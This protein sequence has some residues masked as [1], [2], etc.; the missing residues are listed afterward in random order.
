MATPPESF[1]PH[2]LLRA[3]HDDRL[4]DG[5]HEAVS[6]QLHQLAYARIELAGQLEIV[7]LSRLAPQVLARRLLT[8]TELEV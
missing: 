3:E 2:A 1:D 5:G 6:E 4:V 7:D 8:Q